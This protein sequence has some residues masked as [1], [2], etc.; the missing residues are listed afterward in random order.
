MF[1]MGGSVKGGVYQCSNN[2]WATGLTGAMFQ[3]N[4]RYLQRTVDYRS[5]LG[6]IIRKHLG[7]TQTELNGIIPGYADPNERL[8]SGGMSSD[9]TPIVGEVGLL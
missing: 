1:I 8:L 7:A 9:N 4:D 5:V 3:V 2:T 6:E